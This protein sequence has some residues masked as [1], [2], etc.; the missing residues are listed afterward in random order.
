MGDAQSQLPL[1][2]RLALSLAFSGPSRSQSLT[3]LLRI[4]VSPAASLDEAA[5]RRSEDA[6]NIAVRYAALTLAASVAVVVLAVVWVVPM[7]AAITSPRVD[8]AFVSVAQAA[9]NV[10]L[11]RS[12]AG[13]VAYVVL[14]TGIVVLAAVC[15][16]VLL[17]PIVYLTRRWARACASTTSIALALDSQ[18]LSDSLATSTEYPR[19]QYALTRMLGTVRLSALTS[20]SSGRR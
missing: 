8:P 1:S 7:L 13:D 19:T 3:R 10:G 15:A 14:M 17:I 5:L 16:A 12:A 20:A 4:E 18:P 9:L 6:T 2:A 11:S